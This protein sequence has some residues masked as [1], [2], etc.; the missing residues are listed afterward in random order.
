MRSREAIIAEE[1]RR[2]VSTAVAEGG[3][4]SIADGVARIVAVC[5]QSGLSK[6]QLGDELMMA[7][8]AAGVAVEIGP[9][10]RAIEKNELAA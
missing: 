4:L 2:V 1:I 9:A 8:V 6:R 10:R 3:V 7:A 5:P